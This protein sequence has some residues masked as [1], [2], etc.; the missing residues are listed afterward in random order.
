MPA[1]SQTSILDPF[2]LQLL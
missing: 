1:E 2:L